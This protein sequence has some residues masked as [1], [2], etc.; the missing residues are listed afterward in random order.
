MTQGLLPVFVV[1]FV[2][3]SFIALRPFSVR[4][5]TAFDVLCFIVISL[6]LYQGRT[7]PFHMVTGTLDSTSLWMRALT[8]LWWLFGA[9]L[10]VIGLSFTLNS[11]RRWREARLF[12][13]LTAAAIYIAAAL[14]VL[15]SVL[16]LPIGGLL[17]TS[18]IVAIVLGLALQNTLADVFAGIAV[19][20]ETPF[21]V[22]DRIL[23]GDK[24]EGQVVQIN[25]RSIHVQT[26]SDDVAIIPN[27]V[28]AKS[29]LVN[30][31]FPTQ[32]RAASVELSCPKSAKS[33]RVIEALLQ[34]TMLC[35]T[36][37][38]NPAPTAVLTRLGSKRSFY[39][40]NFYA[41]DTGALGAAKGA[42]LLQCQRQL[43][44]EGL[45]DQPMNAGS[46]HTQSALP[47]TPIPT[48]ELLQD[49]IL[50][51]GLNDEQVAKLAS[52]LE[53]RLLEPGEV[54]FAQGI[55]GGTLFIV[56]SGIVEIARRSANSSVD[57][58]GC[59]GA[60]D[61]LGEISLLTGAPYAATATARTHCQIYALPH[62]VIAPLLAANA[63]LF[64]VFDKLA[65][66]GTEALHRKVAVRAAD[67]IGTAGQF[68]L[69]IR[70]FFMKS[71]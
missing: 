8:A 52:H 30:R 63:Q 44:Y 40:V 66:R 27:S 7:S 48:A 59:V 68:V 3:I 41:A 65:R 28:V 17:A 12:P 53:L 16:S 36:I 62:E 67:D 69:R 25:W 49:V 5:K 23:L 2:I 26:D 18:G 21:C 29:E 19:G 39:S 11:N 6:L 1:A 14:V 32:R 38:R 9:R 71:G 24:I 46:R 31:S 56:A 61:Y 64:S 42:L 60:G 45:L 4:V 33:E 10:V 20:I 35:P 15:T 57:S 51:Q 55:S 70:H 58:I 37:L 47:T 34:A 13:D 22:G 54:L 43:Y 50:F